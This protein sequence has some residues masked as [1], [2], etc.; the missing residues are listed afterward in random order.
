M[1][2]PA[3]YRTWLHTERT[4]STPI[5]RAP[6]QSSFPVPRCPSTAL[7]SSSHGDEV[8]DAVMEPAPTLVTVSLWRALVGRQSATLCR[9]RLG[10]AKRLPQ[11]GSLYHHS[12]ALLPTFRLVVLTRANG[13]RRSRLTDVK[14]PAASVKGSRYKWTG[15]RRTDCMTRGFS[16]HL[17]LKP[18]QVRGLQRTGAGLGHRSR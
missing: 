5:A 18:L 16:R 1:R 11:A 2:S 15:A 7:S 13:C 12:Q 6:C 14:T 4:K 10:V 8:K 17:A 9:Q 3:L